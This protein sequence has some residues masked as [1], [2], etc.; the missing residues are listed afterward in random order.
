[1]EDQWSS[2]KCG[3]K[4]L[5]YMS[6]GIPTVMSPVGVNT[7]IVEDSK[8]GFIAST[9]AEW[10]NSLE[11]LL[12]DSELRMKLGKSGKQTIESRYSVHSQ[13]LAYL[14]LFS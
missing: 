9:T 5:Q 8:N 3:F 6:L 10:K 13:R 14:S 7:D 4:G 1:V 11:L 2:G 12:S